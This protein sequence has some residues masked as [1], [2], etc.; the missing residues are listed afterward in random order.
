M[1]SMMVSGL[2]VIALGAESSA[3][4]TSDRAANRSVDFK[5]VRDK[6]PLGL[7]DTAAFVA[8]LKQAREIKPANHADDAQSE[9]I[10]QEIPEHC[11]RHR[12]IPLL[13]RGIARRVYSSQS[14][15]AA[16]NRLLEV[17]ITTPRKGPNPIACV[18]E[19]PPPS[20]PDRPVIS[21]PVVVHGFFLK[22]MAYKV[23]EKEFVA[24]LLIGTLEHHPNPD[25]NV[26]EPPPDEVF[27]RLPEGAEIRS[28]GPAAEEKLSL[29]LDRNGRLSIDGEAIARKGLARKLEG[30]AASIRFNVRAGGVLLPADHELPA[31][32]T[33]RAPDETPCTTIY[34]LMLDCQRCG[35]LKYALEYANDDP[36]TAEPANPPA[37]PPARKPNTLPDEQRTI[38]VRL[39]ADQKGQIGRFQLGNQTLQ[40]FEALKRALTE[41]LNDPNAPFDRANWLDPRLRY[42][43]MVRVAKTLTNPP[44]TSIHFTMAEA[45]GRR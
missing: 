17:W 30:L 33:F 5:S 31:A 26:I 6:A 18:I 37:S 34:K 8:L 21:E 19:E 16:G 11:D 42:F 7:R 25:Q 24:P 29:K 40:G 1:S 43:E 41:I 4:P 10:L 3:Q 35:F 14:P 23:G 44:V 15:L 32:L 20:F 38:Q 2:V 45:S 27:V 12:G 39:R 22:L 13:V 9:R 36:A 28:V